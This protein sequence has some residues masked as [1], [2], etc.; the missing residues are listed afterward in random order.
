MSSTHRTGKNVPPLAPEEEAL[1]PSESE[2][3]VL[4]KRA[5]RPLGAESSGDAVEAAK[6]LPSHRLYRDFLMVKKLCE[7]ALSSL[8][9][10]EGEKARQCELQLSQIDGDFQ[11]R[12]E[13]LRRELQETAERLRGQLGV[14]QA[15]AGKLDD[16]LSYFQNELAMCRAEFYQQQADQDRRRLGKRLKELASGAQEAFEETPA[17]ELFRIMLKDKSKEA[18]DAYYRAI[19][20]PK[21]GVNRGPERSSKERDAGMAAPTPVPVVESPLLG[22]PLFVGGAFSDSMPSTVG[23]ILASQGTPRAP[24]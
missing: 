16:L 23:G 21:S 3:A 13:E 1:P 8:P 7:Q 5:G 17:A 14:V 20:P 2:A 24:D 18:R 22:T 4:D 10:A 12:V 19:G 15:L 9:T 6:F 11:L